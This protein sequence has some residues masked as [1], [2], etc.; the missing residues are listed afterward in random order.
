MNDLYSENLQC[1]FDSP[2]IKQN[3]INIKGNFIYELP[4]ARV[5][6]RLKTLTR[7]FHC[8]K[9]KIFH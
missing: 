3:L 4:T 1:G 2:R 7:E 5:A 6:E 8:T 9:K